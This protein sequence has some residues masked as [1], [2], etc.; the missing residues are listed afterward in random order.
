MLFIYVMV[1]CPLMLWDLFVLGLP[2]EGG[3]AMKPLAPTSIELIG[4]AVFWVAIAWNNHIKEILDGVGRIAT[5]IAIYHAIQR[6]KDELFKKKK[7]LS[8]EQEEKIL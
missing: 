4:I 6:V 5:I 7:N 3:L 2:S 8:I 1:M